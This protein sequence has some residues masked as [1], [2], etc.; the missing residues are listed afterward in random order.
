IVTTLRLRHA[1]HVTSIAGRLVAARPVRS[2]NDRAGIRSALSFVVLLASACGRPPA[3]TGSA[4]RA[5]PAPAMSTMALPAELEPESEA[6][7]EAPPAPQHAVELALDGWLDDEEGAQPVDRIVWDETARDAL[8]FDGQPWGLTDQF[9]VHATLAL[10]GSASPARFTIEV[11][12]CR[13]DPPRGPSAGVTR[14]F[15][16]R[17]RWRDVSELARA[18]DGCMAL[19]LGIDAD[20]WIHGEPARCPATAHA[21]A[22]THC[23]HRICLSFVLFDDVPPDESALAQTAGNATFAWVSAPGSAG[24]CD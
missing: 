8:V 3:R 17:L 22:A 11:Q 21:Y 12:A 16:T 23:S 6:E 2:W 9:E 19:A 13:P 1:R 24:P 18:P 14:A 10:A 20:A 7:P 15:G 5:E 4:A